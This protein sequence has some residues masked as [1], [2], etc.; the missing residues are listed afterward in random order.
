MIGSVAV[1]LVFAAAGCRAQSPS[2]T[3]SQPPSIPEPVSAARDTSHGLGGFYAMASGLVDTIRPGNLPHGT[4]EK[5]QNV[6]KI[7]RVQNSCVHTHAHTYAP[8]TVGDLAATVSDQLQLDW[9]IPPP[10][11]DVRSLVKEVY[12]ITHSLSLSLSVLQ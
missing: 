7:L 1:V 2:I 11:K 9:G 12:N 8:D 3:F 5:S 4:S 10:D 6:C